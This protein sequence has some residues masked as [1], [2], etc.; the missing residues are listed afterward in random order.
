MAGTGRCEPRAHVPG[1][2]QRV[3]LREA[4]L[5]RTGT[6]PSTGAWYG[7]GSAA[8][9]AVKNGALRCVRGMKIH[10][11]RKCECIPIPA[12]QTCLILRVSCPVRGASRGDPE[13]GQSESWLE[14][15]NPDWSMWRPRLCLASMDPGGLGEPSGPTTRLCLQWLD[16]A[17]EGWAKA[18]LDGELRFAPVP[19]VRPQGRRSRCDG[20]SERRFCYYQGASFGAPSPLK[21]GGEN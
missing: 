9:H 13:V 17:G 16:G 15:G 10:R 3:S 11:S 14:R 1:A 20:A 12:L 5:R 4:L 8:Q 21:V 6:F 7:P 2:M 18:C 19:E